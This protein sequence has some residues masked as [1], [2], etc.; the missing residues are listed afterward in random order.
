M[1]YPTATLSV[2]DINSDPGRLDALR[3]AAHSDSAAAAAFDRLTRLASTVLSAPIA[4][5]GFVDNKQ[6]LLTSKHGLSPH[7]DEILKAPAAG[8]LC[9]RVIKSRRPLILS[10]SR[11]QKQ[12][13]IGSAIKGLSA[14]S[15][16][17]LPLI[18]TDAHLLGVFCVVDYFERDWT[19][20]QI[21]SFNDLAQAVVSEI[22][23][24][25]AHYLYEKYAR[26]LALQNEH[27]L[28]LRE[29]QYHTEEQLLH[30]G[31]DETA[32][33]RA[34]TARR[35]IESILEGITDGF[36]AL[37]Q[38]MR[39]TYINDRAEKLLHRSRGELI[40]TRLTDHPTPTDL[41]QRLREVQLS[42][43]PMAFEFNDEDHNSFF[44]I[45]AYPSPT[46]ISVYFH[47]VTERKRVVDEIERRSIELQSL[48]RRLVEVQEQER[49]QIARELHDEVGQI[50]TGLK[51]TLSAA[52]R[53]P[54]AARDTQLDQA[55][56]LVNELIGHVR[57]LSLDLRPAMLDDLGLLPACSGISNDIHVKQ[58]SVLH[59]INRRSTADLIRR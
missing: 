45:L 6:L 48:S 31:F 26:D 17:G 41:V 47:D 34:E 46:G 51:L 44:E 38:S 57:D 9:G 49:G 32:R 37:D 10:S 55:Q 25:A 7:W 50:L 56:L 23:L 3:V 13:R 12:N 54:D 58:V 42:N 53:L 16:A 29:R 19:D 30:L 59:S 4:L 18:T 20:D 33:E 2:Y 40:E 43:A 1:N 36:F 28:M 22:E 14:V 15:F 21:S 35:Q 8:S 24:R 39:F 11:G 52:R 27:N 5:I